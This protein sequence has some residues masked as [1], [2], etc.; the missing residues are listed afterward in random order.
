MKVIGIVGGVASGKSL[1][2]EQFRQLGAEVLDG[3]RE[4]HQ[5]LHEESV[6]AELRKKWG[7]KVFNE[8]G[9]VDRSA[10]AAIVFADTTQAA[11]ELKYLEQLVHPKI[12]ERLKRRMSQIEN[13][14]KTNVVVLDAAVMFKAGWD[15]YCD[16]I[17]YVDV[18]RQLRLERAHRRGWSDKHFE[19]REKSQQSLA[20][21]RNRADA[22]IDNSGDPAATL[23]QVERLWKECD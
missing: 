11:E 3:D 23:A 22:V 16:M 2:A 7:E 6:K 5:V 20:D 1:V 10:V 8:S 9:E 14:Q 18:D 13:E 17:V 15:R 12:G 19:S 21:K 4:A